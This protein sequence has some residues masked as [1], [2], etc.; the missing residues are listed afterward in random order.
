MA[1]VVDPIVWVAT[2]AAVSERVSDYIFH[3]PTGSSVPGMA[4]A[5]PYLNFPPDE[6]RSLV[7]G[8]QD[9][10]K[11]ALMLSALRQWERQ[12]DGLCYPFRRASVAR[13]LRR[14]AARVRLA[15][16]QGP[17][18]NM[19]YYQDSETPEGF[20]SI[21]DSG[22][23]QNVHDNYDYE[24][25][26]YTRQ[27]ER[28]TID[29]DGLNGDYLSPSAPPLGGVVRPQGDGPDPEGMECPLPATGGNLDGGP[30]L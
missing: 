16:I 2:G 23:L 19:F 22:F 7:R 6:I 10:A 3:P 27:G 14:A 11:V 21:L 8:E 20:E 15:E 30:W 26:D 1:P 12:F 28:P 9:E 25:F 24:R 18:F 4:E 17:A 5:N 13:M 29:V